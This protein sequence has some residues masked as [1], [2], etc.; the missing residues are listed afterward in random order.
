MALNKLPEEQ[1]QAYNDLIE[2]I[3][4]QN[5]DYAD[6][7]MKA[8]LWIV[9]AKRPLK[10]EELLYALAIEPGDTSLDTD[11]VSESSLVLSVCAGIV[12]FEPESRIVGLVHYTAQEYLARRGPDVFPDA[13]REMTLIC[14][15]ALSFQA[16]RDHYYEVETYDGNAHLQLSRYAVSYWAD[17]MRDSPDDPMCQELAL[18][19]VCSQGKL[20]METVRFQGVGILILLE[21]Q[22]LAYAA[23]GLCVL[24]ALGLNSAMASLINEDLRLHPSNTISMHCA[25]LCA[26]FHGRTRT[27]ALLIEQGASVNYRSADT[28]TALHYAAGKNHEA[29]TKLL[30][31]H[32]ATVDAVA[33]IRTYYAQ[34]L[35]PSQS[36]REWT[37]LHFAASLGH[38]NI[39][40]LLLQRGAQL[41]RGDSCGHT[42]LHLA[43]AANA[44][45]V[46]KVLLK[47]YLNPL[48]VPDSPITPIIH[49]AAS[50]NGTAQGSRT[51][52]I[53]AKN[54]MKQTALHLAAFFRSE[55]VV[56]LLIEAGADL[57]A[58]DGFD[59]TP[60]LVAT[61][62]RDTKKVIVEA[63]LEAG[64]DVNA[65]GQI[66]GDTRNTALHLAIEPTK[67][68]LLQLL[69]SNGAIA[70]SRNNTRGFTPMHLATWLG[71]GIETY[72]LLLDS[73]VDVNAQ[74]LH[75]NTVLH[76]LV[77]AD[78][79]FVIKY[80]LENGAKAGIK[81]REDKTA[82]DL[83]I[84]W[85][86]INPC[87]LSSVASLLKFV[88]KNPGVTVSTASLVSLDL[89]PR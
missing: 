84:Q 45:D 55:K 22:H 71:S 4:N 43:V 11:G 56:P 26:V 12:T 6:L 66:N 8:L 28:E 24:A 74:D 70:D 25:L 60:L 37:A 5:A 82:G 88:E 2:R 40:Q 13:Q 68:E 15:T 31:E 58:R 36:H 61:H 72:K 42:A 16:A 21:L 29:I 48:Q 3:R 38:S 33:N 14:L 9:N 51:V 77:V 7:A 18:D 52:S 1:D 76:L 73:G 19:F 63:L 65:A 75:G 49:T 83:A 17:H 86:A 87:V 39:V 47:E 10:M 85:R 64:A 59:N 30:L 57:D 81:N 89:W 50:A 32:G 46:V 67:F 62:G 35:Y 80:F 79:I 54:N 34:H 53:N 44:C 41:G 20:A 27:A 78:D 69:L 23:S